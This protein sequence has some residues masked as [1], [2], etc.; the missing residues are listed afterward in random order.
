[1]L[2]EKGLIWMKYTKQSPLMSSSLHLL[3]FEHEYSR[4]S[5]I[6]FIE[7]WRSFFSS[8]KLLLRIF[9][10]LIW[11]ISFLILIQ[12]ILFCIVMTRISIIF[13]KFKYFPL[14]YT[15]EVSWEIRISTAHFYDFHSIWFAL[16]VSELKH[17]LIWLEKTPPSKLNKIFFLLKLTDMV[18]DF[19]CSSIINEVFR[20]IHLRCWTFSYENLHFIAFY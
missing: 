2:Y 18:S 14:W 5:F 4:L 11:E 6:N 17:I 15:K 1:M 7:V 3:S 19:K 13:V 20:F 16:N 12:W 8:L 10:I 9:Y